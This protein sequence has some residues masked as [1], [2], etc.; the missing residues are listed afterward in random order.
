MTDKITDIELFDFCEA[1]HNFAGEINRHT[2]DEFITERINT[3]DVKAMMLVYKLKGI[4]IPET[5]RTFM[6][7]K[8]NDQR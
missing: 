7:E 3:L 6:E 4:E 8:P 1:V 5:I 2:D